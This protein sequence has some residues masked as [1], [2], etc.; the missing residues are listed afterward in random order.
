MKR[1]GLSLLMS[2]QNL[3]SRGSSP[4]ASMSSKKGASASPERWRNSMRGPDIRDAYLA[5]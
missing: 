1:E 4:I 5:L 2:E 3:A